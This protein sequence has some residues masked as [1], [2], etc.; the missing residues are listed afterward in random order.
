M[1]KSKSIIILQRKYPDEINKLRSNLKIDDI[2]LIKT[3]ILMIIMFCV[4]WG[5]YAL[6]TIIA[7]FAENITSYINPFTT[8]V[9]ALFAKT[10]HLMNPIIFTFRN[11]KFLKFLKLNFCVEISKQRSRSNHTNSVRI[12]YFHGNAFI[13]KRNYNYN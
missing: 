10:S 3:I 7:Q 5:P 11:K 6:V 1:P 12:K 13:R 4:S 2:K 8:C 9:P